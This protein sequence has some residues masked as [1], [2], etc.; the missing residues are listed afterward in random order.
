M[1]SGKS[2]LPRSNT[3][4]PGKQVQNRLLPALPGT[5]TKKETIIAYVVTSC[6]LTA[7]PNAIDLRKVTANHL[8]HAHYSY[9]K[10]SAGYPLAALDQLSAANYHAMERSA[11]LLG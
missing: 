1:R 11:D 4:L 2:Y 7:I 6:F 10:T 5:T 8:S 9:Q 3:R